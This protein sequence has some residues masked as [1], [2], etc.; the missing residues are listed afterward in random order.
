MGGSS[1]VWWRGVKLDSRTAAMMAEV[2]RLTPNMPT[3][4]P[5]Q[6]SYNTSVDASAGTHAGGGAID[7]SVRNLSNSEEIEL[8]RLLRTVGFAAYIRPYIARLWPKHI[9]AIAIGCP[10][11]SR[12]AA[13]QVD[14]YKAGRNG[15]ANNGPDPHADLDVPFTTWE[16]YLGKDDAVAETVIKNESVWK[17]LFKKA[18]NTKERMYAY[19]YLRYIHKYAIACKNAVTHR[20]G[21]NSWMERRWGKHS[22]SPRTYWRSAYGHARAAH[23]IADEN[24]KTLAKILPLVQAAAQGRHLSDADV[25]RIAVAAADAVPAGVAVDVVDELVERLDDSSDETND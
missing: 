14:D 8:I 15:L 18:T 25:Q 2:A 3:I 1:I 10:D 12:A 23:E 21:F 19:N 5:T 16:Q 22:Y 4:T 9:H 13:N 11:L 17:S 20:I 24:R 6:G 7:I